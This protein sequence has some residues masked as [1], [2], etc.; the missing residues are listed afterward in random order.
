M[1]LALCLTSLFLFLFVGS[2]K[3]EMVPRIVIDFM[4][5]NNDTYFLIALAILA[6]VIM[7]LSIL[8]R[9]T[10]MKVSNKGMIAVMLFITAIFTLICWFPFIIGIVLCIAFIILMFFDVKKDKYVVE[11]CEKV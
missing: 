9:Y 8:K 1:K 10:V 6:C 5:R 3:A 4:E 11:K 7:I 2:A